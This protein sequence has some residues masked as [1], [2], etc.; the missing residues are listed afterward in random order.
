MGNN[1]LVINN[2]NSLF[3][4]FISFLVS[5]FFSHDYLYIFLF[6]L[7]D[8]VLWAIKF[9]LDVSLSDKFASEKNDII[10]FYIL[11]IFPY[12]HHCYLFHFFFYRHCFMGDKV[13]VWTSLYATSL[14][15]E[16]EPLPDVNKVFI[17][18][19]S[20]KLV[21]LDEYAGPGCLNSKSRYIRRIQKAG[22]GGGPTWGG[23]K[24]S[25]YPLV[26]TLF[27]SHYPFP[28]LTV[29]ICVFRK[30]VGGGKNNSAHFIFCSHPHV[31]KMPNIWKISHICAN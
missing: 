29:F 12:S 28:I 17:V 22:V 15:V 9:M 18:P 24:K 7:I 25:N 10:I 20:I 30:Q 11:Y 1:V 13:L 2:I 26:Y 16:N 31:L 21:K 5:L 27:S 6:F 19:Q 23:G 4:F 14:L 8:T 3:S